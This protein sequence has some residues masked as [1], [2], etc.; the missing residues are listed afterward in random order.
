MNLEAFEKNLNSH[1]TNLSEMLSAILETEVENQ[2]F[3]RTLLINQAILFEKNDPSKT[4]GEYEQEFIE[5]VNEL[6]NEKLATVVNRI[7]NSK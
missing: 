1:Y 6:K 4:A 3:L 2:A 7:S 5:T